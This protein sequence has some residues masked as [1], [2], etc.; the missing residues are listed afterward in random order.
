MPEVAGKQVEGSADHGLAFMGAALRCAG[1]VGYPDLSVER[2]CERCDRTRGEFGRRFRS[3]QDCFAAAYAREGERVQERLRKAL[4]E[5]GDRLDGVRAALSEAA[6]AA[7]SEPAMARAFLLEV[8][9]S[10]LPGA[11]RRQELL[12]RL[13][14][15]LD[16]AR[17]TGGPR[18]EPTTT[19]IFVVGA[20]EGLFAGALVRGDFE[21]LN[22][23]V[24]E[25]AEL[26]G[27]ALS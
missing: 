18:P 4:Q 9:A 14:E 16:R 17:G 1:E 23:M 8:H 20:V 7:A 27:T 10:G 25:L 13:A 3:K 22:A 21:G 2:I 24:P 19:S 15:E 12:D 11:R 6:A 26:V 5:E